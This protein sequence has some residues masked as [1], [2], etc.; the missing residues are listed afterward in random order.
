MR[1]KFW[2]KQDNLPELITFSPEE[3]QPSPEYSINLSFLPKC[4]FFI[5]KDGV[6]EDHH[7]WVI[8]EVAKI[9]AGN[10]EDYIKMSG[11]NMVYV[12][13][14]N[15]PLQYI[16]PLITPKPSE[17]EITSTR[18]YGMAETL[19]KNITEV[20]LLRRQTNR[21]NP[22]AKWGSMTGYVLAFVVLV[23]ALIVI[24]AVLFGNSGDTTDG[25]TDTVP[26]VTQPM[27]PDLTIPTPTPDVPLKPIK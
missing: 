15:G 20:E 8:R 2:K 4:V 12:A 10:E 13:V 14:K 16:E 7:P 22:W 27:K 9:V 5:T 1:L 17:Y 11:D 6:I 18:L 25:N 24:V 3:P 19:S 23:M 21:P 26:G